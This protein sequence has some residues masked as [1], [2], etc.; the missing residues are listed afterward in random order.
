MTLRNIKHILFSNFKVL[1]KLH[2]ANMSS[3]P[4]KKAKIVS[5]VFMENRLK[6]AENVNEFQ[7]NKK[8]IKL[9]SGS[10]AFLR[11]E[12]KSVAYYMH[13]DQRVQDNWAMLYAQKLAM[14]HGLPLHVISMISVTHPNDAG[15]THRTIKFSLNGLEEVANDLKKLNIAFHFILAQNEPTP[16]KKIADLMSKLNIGCLIVDFSALRPHRSIVQQIVDSKEIKGRPVYQVDAHNIVPVTVTSEKQEYAARTIRNKVTGKLGEFLTEFPPVISHPYGDCTSTPRQFGQQ[17]GNDIKDDWKEMLKSIKK[18]ETVLPVDK[19]QPG[20]AEGHKALQKFVSKRIKIYDEKRNDPNNDAVSDLSPWFHFGQLSVQR[21]VLYV[22]KEASSYS[23]GFIEESVVRRELSENFC[24][25]NE[26]YD[27][28]KGAT[29]WAKKTLN[30]HKKD[31]RPYLYTR[32]Q[33]EKALTHD[34]LWNAAQLQLR[35]EGKMHGF[36][37]MYWAKKVLEWTESP[38]TALADALYLN[39]HYSLDGNDA[40]GVVGCMWSICGVHDQ[41]W[42]ERAIFGKVRFMNFD[43]C[44]RK[45]DIEKYISKH[46]SRGK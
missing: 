6:V 9:L 18:D 29:D 10:E 44:K 26:N 28:V 14:E 4:A 7:F 21:A 39:D 1:N 30:D 40:N 31:K 22:K 34:R 13:R 43:G 36:M 3:P 45:F 8:R 46:G 20:T 2:C 5:D 12:C 16:G 37:R 11:Q 32:E 17:F 41:G 24:Y 23:K 25:Y 19:F 35:N 27:S 15:A 38:E 42:G 33:L